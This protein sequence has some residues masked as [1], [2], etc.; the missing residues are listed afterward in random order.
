MTGA[1]GGAL[2]GARVQPICPRQNART[3]AKLMRTVRSIETLTLNPAESPSIDRVF[4][5]LIV[6]IESSSVGVRH[7]LLKA[8]AMGLD[9]ACM[10][11]NALRPNGLR[12]SAVV[13]VRGGDRRVVAVGRQVWLPTRSLWSQLRTLV[14]IQVE[15]EHVR[16][17]N[18]AA[19]SELKSK[20]VKV[21]YDP[22]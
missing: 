5:V 17:A 10:F 20:Q 19:P 9:I 21:G 14:Q 18:R 22:S 7:V 8:R 16:S 13:A 2:A 12:A 11:A 3:I 6:F 15:L 1:A 4:I